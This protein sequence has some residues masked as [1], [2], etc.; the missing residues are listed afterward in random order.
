MDIQ[1]KNIEKKHLNIVKLINELSL[2]E[3]YPIQLWEHWIEKYNNYSFIAENNNNVLGYIICDND[4][5]ISLAVR[6][7]Y[8]HNNIGKKLMTFCLKSITNDIKLCCRK[9]NIIALNLYKK[10]GFEI[11]YEIENY[12]SNP[13]ENG[14][15][16]IRKYKL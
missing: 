5:I 16:L 4:K 10:N 14:Y 8:R 7:N 11:Q 13:K 1:I 2:P 6:D 15:E 3:R 12:Y 9:S